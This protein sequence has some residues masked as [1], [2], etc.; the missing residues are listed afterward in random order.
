MGGRLFNQLSSGRVCLFEVRPDVDAV[1]GQA[2]REARVLAFFAD[3]QRKL[4]IA[5]DHHRGL[6]GLIDSDFLNLCR[7]EG[8]GNELS[9]VL[10][11]LD[12][13][14]FLTA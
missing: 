1:T 8:L 13:V 10:S 3:C 7:S 4:M 2:G 14:D 9:F 5:D 11:P 6:I 12:D